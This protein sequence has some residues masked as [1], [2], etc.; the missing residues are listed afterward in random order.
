MKKTILTL[1]KI[2]SKKEQA[3]INGEVRRDP[4]CRM[5]RYCSCDGNGHEILSELI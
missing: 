3:N 1:G 4:C 5:P 2:L